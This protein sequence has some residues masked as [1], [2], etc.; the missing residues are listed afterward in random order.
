MEFEYII[1]AYI[2]TQ[3]DIPKVYIE[4]NLKE[5][6]SYMKQVNMNN[7]ILFPSSLAIPFGNL[8]ILLHFYQMR[9]NF[10]HL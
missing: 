4:Y 10:W 9:I 1:E 3:L 6:I 5:D 7:I 8:L 2:N